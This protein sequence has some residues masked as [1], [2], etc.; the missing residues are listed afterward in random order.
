MFVKIKQQ[1][2]EG[3]CVAT[4]YYEKFT[5]VMY[6]KIDSNI[7]VMLNREGKP[8]VYDG[9]IVTAILSANSEESVSWE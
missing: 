6:V 4:F 7:T 8:L 3:G 2:L 5:R 9:Q 1:I